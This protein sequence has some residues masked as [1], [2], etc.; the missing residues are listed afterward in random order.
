MD[1]SLKTGTLDS[2]SAW[3]LYAALL[4]GSLWSGSYFP[5]PKWVF[6][7][8]L[9]AAGAWELAVSLEGGTARLPRSPAFWLLTPF[10]LFAA[11]GVFWSLAPSDTVRETLLL[12]GYL[13]VVYVMAGNL[14][15]R[16][17]AA[18]QVAAWMV[19]AAAFI[20]AWGVGAYIMRAQPYTILLDGV[21][22]AG[23]TF[24]YSNALSCFCL[25]ALPLTW[26]LL[27][28][29]ADRDRALFA[30]AASIQVTAV[31][32]AF[33]RLG[34]ALLAL[35]TVFYLA[36]SWRRRMLP[37]LLLTL[38]TGLPAAALAT[39]LAGSGRQAAAAAAAGGM[40]LLAWLGQGPAA[41]VS[42]HR[43]GAAAAA[44]VAAAALAAAALLTRL[45][46]SLDLAVTRR[47]RQGIALSKLLPH[48]LDTY[49][50]TAAA[51]HAHPVAGSGLGTFA[52]VYQQYAITS[53]TKF[54]H[55]LVLQMAVDTG[56]IGAVLFSL[57]LVYAAAAG[58]WRLLKGPDMLN[59]GFALAALVFIAYN[60]VD[61]EWYVPALTAWFLVVL[62]AM[63]HRWEEVRPRP[64]GRS[65]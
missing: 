10:T 37:E 29:A 21:Y 43:L 14:R 41:R 7:V 39:A 38:A 28:T 6:I 54:A 30:A 51:F 59:R 47:F 61:W 56:V 40:A 46:E 45:S 23:S 53:Y 27:I 64:P 19:Y 35:L 42:G 62:A 18:A 55:N 3:L 20:G 12:C 17:G 34:M 25:M 1:T 8:L 57:F 2:G 49:S 16:P 52:R 36:A 24:E 44:A 32:L 58:I 50:G 22:R 15:R 13:S 4:T 65:A 26:A 63:E 33:S 11:A 31:V 48:R 5:T 9:L 60:M